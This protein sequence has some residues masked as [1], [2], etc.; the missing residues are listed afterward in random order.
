MIFRKILRSLAIIQLIFFSFISKSIACDYSTINLSNQVLNPDGSNTFTLDV[1]VE[2]GTF[3]VSYYGFTLTF[4]SSSGTPQVVLGGAYNTT[5][6]IS[7]PLNSG[8]ISGSLI[9]LTN[10]DINSVVN[11]ACWDKYENQINTISYES[12]QFWGATSNDFSTTIE[13][14][15]MGCVEEIALDAHPRM[16]A[17]FSCDSP[18]CLKLL[19]INNNPF[20]EVSA[21]T[22]ICEND[23]VELFVDTAF[24]GFLS[25]QFTMSFNT[26]FSYTSTNTNLPGIYYVL[27]SGTYFGASNETRDACYGNGWYNGYV[28]SP[29]IA[30]KWNGVNPSTQAQIPTSYNSNHQ[31]QLFFNGGS[32][33]TFSFNDSGSYLDNGGSLD[34]KIYYLGNLSWSNGVTTTNNMVNP[35]SNTT[36]IATIDLGGCTFSD[37]VLVSVNPQTT[38]LDT[39]VACSSYTWSNGVTYTSSNNNATQ[40]LINSN[41]CDSTVTLNLTIN[42]IST[43]IDSHTACGSYTWQDGNTYTTNNNT[44]THILTN[45]LGCDSIITLDLTIINSTTGT[46]TQTACD[47]FTWIDGNNYTSSNSIA[48]HTLTN[49]V[50]CDSIVSLNL[51]I[52]NSTSGIDTQIACNSFTWIDG[53][54]YSNSNS[55][56]THV[57]TNNVGCDSNVTLNLTINNSSS[58]TD[59]FTVCDSLT[60]TNGITYTSSNNSAIQ[61]LTNN[62]GCDSV[63]TLNLTVNNT[64]TGNDSQTACDSLTWIDGV[65][66][67]NSNSIAT[68]S[69]TNLNGCDSIVT[70]DL[71]I[72]NSSYMDLYDTICLNELPITWEGQSFTQQGNQIVNYISA[73]NCDST[74]SLNLT[75][76]DTPNVYIN[77]ND[78]TICIDSSILLYGNGA[79]SY[80]W[81]NNLIIDSLPFIPIENSFY[82]VTGTDSNNC[83]SNSSIFIELVTC[84]NIPFTIQIPNSFTPNFD[85]NNDEFRIN[86]TS[87]EITSI[88]IFNRWGQVIF[89]ASNNLPWDGRLSSGEKSPEGT[90]YYLIKF[91]AFKPNGNFDNKTE[92]GSVS[93]FR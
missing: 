34:F 55:T 10:N 77:I 38:G 1:F 33:Q 59:A 19:N 22:S 12:N 14:T 51:T 37:D 27:I 26:P 75:I 65:T 64:N 11:D 93:L 15:V 72:N 80:S 58:F 62:V 70:L 25:E 29:G 49:T 76:N 28:W 74:L 81:N 89:N 4:N 88:N 35:T 56:A 5:S 79:S 63:V 83:S 20:I 92:K 90:Y 86:G 45:S 91:K 84:Y 87:F 53:N 68:F 57:L 7:N 16:S 32:A 8:S 60:W 17:G 39:Q 54:S 69:L 82:E 23:N 31:Y 43:S 9:G 46:D 67:L 42:P 61:V 6:T 66:Y 48:T 73:A 52:T 41:G 40:T 30:W 21:D 44:S 47:L 71:T 2:L 13:V 78:T 50:G 24:G 3:D 18:L 36:Y 85:G